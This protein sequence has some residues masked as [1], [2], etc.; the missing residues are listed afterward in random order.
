[1]KS[2]ELQLSP[3]ARQAAMVRGD[4]WRITVL[5]DRLLR[6][7]YDETGRFTDSAT[8]TVLCRD[9][10]VPAFTVEKPA[11]GVTVI[12][13][14]R[15]RLFYDGQRFSP[16][17]LRVEMSE[18][19]HGF[20]YCWRYGD[21][22]RDLGGTARTL[23][24]AD[25]RIPLDSGLMS[26]DGFTVL[27]DSHTAL[28]TP[29]LWVEPRPEGGQDLYFFGYGHDYLGCLR[30]FYR[31]S[32]RVPLLPRFA[33]G[34]W[35]SRYHVYS[36]QTYLE[37]MERFRAHGIPLSVAV[38]DM[39]WHLTDLPPHCGSGWTGYTWNR[40]LFPDPE[41]FLRQLHDRGLKVT[42]NV[43]PSE[44][45]GAHEQVYPRMAEALGRDPADR[46][47]IPFEAADQTYMD[48]YFKVLHH[49]LEEQGVDFW[50]VDWQQG[51][52][53]GVPGIDPLWIL[54]HLHFLDSGR[55]G[56]WPMTFSRYAGVGSHRYP[57]GFSGDS[58]IT[59]QSLD[60]QPYFT[61]TA[62]NVGY[63]WWS[64]DIGGHQGGCRDDEL[65]ARWVQLGAFSPIMRLHSTANAFAGKEPWNFGPAA[66]RTMTA[67]MRLRRKLVP[68]LYSMNYLT[69]RE[70]LPLVRPMYYE[71]DCPEAYAVPN[72]Y[73]FGTKM[74]VCPIT[75]PADRQTQMGRFDA[76][77]PAGE[78]Y[79]FFSGRRYTGGRRLQLHRGLD[80]IPVLV[81]AG[82]VIPLDADAESNGVENPGVVELRVWPGADGSFD[83]YEDSGVYGAEPDVTHFDFS[84]GETSRL[85]AAVSGDGSCI[86]AGRRFRV[87]VTGVERPDFVSADGWSYDAPTHTLR[88]ELAAGREGFAAEFAAALACPEPEREVFDILNRAQIAY[89]LKTKIYEAVQRGPDLVHA[90]AVLTALDLPP[91]LFGAVT[92]PMT[93]LL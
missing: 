59:W 78:Y 60:F 42:L 18:P 14:G 86:P 13:T 26:A 10:P 17:G 39:D 7:E 81:P 45:V 92:E 69:H 56:R 25:G 27:D 16:E 41:R 24:G 23:D 8:L 79:D 47:R 34:N 65:A 6:L 66:E 93:A 49:P 29:D 44:G 85:T 75:V 71:S 76:W 50:W 43:H 68:Y 32:G 70:D 57:I 62:S 87:Y 12:N 54:D 82:A 28:I 67:F 9:M 11:D 35:W 15:L 21:V 89:E 53:S 63:T 19:V 20:A 84:W 40:T 38:V 46:E 30:D 80:T 61:A 91:A 72:E 37:L 58:Y 33:L 2:T 77:L 48:A 90:L 73:R 74:I 22:V 64:H 3:M 36:E 4:K 55:D 51:T 88:F 1:M 31:L 52:R 83:M 5:T